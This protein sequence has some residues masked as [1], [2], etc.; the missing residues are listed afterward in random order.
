[1]K[2]FEQASTGQIDDYIMIYDADCPLCNWYTSKFVKHG[3]LSEKGRERY[4]FAGPFVKHSIDMDKARNHI[5][6]HNKTTG[7]TTYGYES[8]ITLLGTKWKWLQKTGKIILIKGV[9]SLLYD[10]ISYNRKIIAPSAPTGFLQC[11][12]DKNLASRFLLILLCLLGVEYTAGSYFHEYFPSFTRLNA[13]PFR[14]TGL[15]LAQLVFQSVLLI[16]SGNKRYIYDYSGHLSVVSLAGGILLA[17][18]SLLFQFLPSGINIEFLSITLLGAVLMWM[19]LE[20]YRR[21][22]I[23]GFPAWLSWTWIIFRIILFLAIFKTIE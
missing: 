14:E 1:M 20:H 13:L 21:I 18:G 17:L 22:R 16:F 12:P 6:L 15:F 23:S 5:A 2:P 9:F 4:Q 3:M 11:I 19:F 8:L 7:R 10:F